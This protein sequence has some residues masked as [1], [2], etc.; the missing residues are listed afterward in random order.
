[1]SAHL[2]KYMKLHVYVYAHVCLCTYV[3]DF[4]NVE[5]CLLGSKNTVMNYC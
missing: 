2:Y 1:M 5:A 4:D 3:T